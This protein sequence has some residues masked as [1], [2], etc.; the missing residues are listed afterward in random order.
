M[1]WFCVPVSSGLG[2]SDG[3]RGMLHTLHED[4][5][6]RGAA[7]C[8]HHSRAWSAEESTASGS[9]GSIFSC[10]SDVAVIDE[11]DYDMSGSLRSSDGPRVRRR[12][13][14]GAAPAAPSFAETFDLSGRCLGHGI[15]GDVV[16]G[17]CRQRGTAF[18]VKQFDLSSLDGRRLDN[19]VREVDIH[20]SVDHPGLLRL[21]A[22]YS[23]STYVH[24]VMEQMRGGELHAAVSGSRLLGESAVARAA[25][26]VLQALAYLHARGIMHRDVKLENIMFEDGQH[27]SVKLCDF[28]FSVRIEPGEKLTHICGTLQYMAPEV[29][30]RT[31]YDC[32][33]DVWSLGVVVFILLTGRL[34]FSGD[35]AEVWSKM[36]EGGVEY[37]AEFHQL[38]KEAQHF[39]RRLL[40]TSPKCRPSALEALRHPWLQ[41]LVPELA[42]PALEEATREAAAS[43]AALAAPPRAQLRLPPPSM[44]SSAASFAKQLLFGSLL[45]DCSRPTYASPRFSLA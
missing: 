21:E 29:S 40:H 11:D 16:E 1:T 2:D 14:G 25:V 23:S 44:V 27:R 30:C 34:P 24:L 13:A 10:H 9:E 28:G 32:K 45:E 26:Q 3:K 42:A 37:T 41:S 17:I 35:A 18:A 4:C 5:D 8:G 39:I 22:V 20:S 15:S 38:S 33:A 12:P 43:P 19:L 36:Q 31:G 6:G 7:H